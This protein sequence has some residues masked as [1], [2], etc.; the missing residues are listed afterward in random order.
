MA[1]TTAAQER[2]AAAAPRRRAGARQQAWQTLAA[3]MT[4]ALQVLQP[5]QFLILSTRH[6]EPYYVQFQR[7]DDGALLA[8]AVSNQFLCGWRALDRI[9]EDRL[10]RLHWRPPTDIGDGPPNWWRH[11]DAG[12]AA[13]LA[14]VAVDTL[15]KAYDVAR[16]DE[17]VYRAGAFGGG[18]LLLPWLDL[19]QREEPTIDEQVE[20][21]FTTL[22]GVDELIR[23]EDGD[24]PIVRDGVTIYVRVVEDPSYVSLFCPVLFDAEPTTE[25]LEAVNAINAEIRCARALWRNGTVVIASEVADGPVIRPHVLDSYEAVSTLGKVYSEQ[26]QERFGTAAAGGT[27]YGFYL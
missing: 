1:A 5:K 23:D 9:A 15:T 26:L 12:A 3:G 18:T 7:A 25:L 2:G 16:V 24:I 17:L 11:A 10:R 22:L 8:E 14:S 21:T 4:V 6:A 20:R 19:E 27:G 13:E